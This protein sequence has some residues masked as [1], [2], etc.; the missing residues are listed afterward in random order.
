MDMKNIIKEANNV[1]HV[2]YRVILYF[3]GLMYFLLFLRL[4]K[5]KMK[6]LDMACVSGEK[7]F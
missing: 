7:Y 5:T 2:S 4:R 3:D 1:F 6:S